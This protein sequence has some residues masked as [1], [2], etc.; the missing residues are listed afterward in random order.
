MNRSERYSR[1]LAALP[2]AVRKRLDGRGALAWQGLA[3]RA[4]VL[5]IEDA[6]RTESRLPAVVEALV[7][8]MVG[9]VGI[10]PAE[11]AGGIEG[12][13]SAAAWMHGIVVE[14]DGKSYR[15]RNERS[16]ELHAGVRPEALVGYAV[17]GMELADTIQ[18]VCEAWAA[19]GEKAQAVRE[20][21]RDTLSLYAGQLGLRLRAYHT[22]ESGPPSTVWLARVLEDTW[23]A[24]SVPAREALAACAI[25]DCAGGRAPRAHYYAVETSCRLHA[26]DIGEARWLLGLSAR[27]LNGEAAAAVRAEASAIRPSPDGTPS[28]AARARE[29]VR[30]LP[31]G[32]SDGSRPVEDSVLR[33]PM[34]EPTTG[35]NGAGRNV[36]EMPA[37]A[38]AAS[39]PVEDDLGLSAALKLV[40]ASRTPAAADRHHVDP[41]LLKGLESLAGTAQDPVPVPAAVGTNQG[42]LV[43]GALAGLQFGTTREGGSP[44]AATE[45]LAEAA[46]RL[47]AAVKQR[48][49]EAYGT[50]ASQGVDRLQNPDGISELRRSL[51]TTLPGTA[52]PEWMEELVAALLLDTGA[53]TRDGLRTGRVRL[54]PEKL[55]E[56]HK[57]IE[58][59]TSEWG[60]FTPIHFVEQVRLGLNFASGVSTAVT[61]LGGAGKEAEWTLLDPAMQDESLSRIERTKLEVTRRIGQE[62]EQGR[63]ALAE[64][65]SG[66]PSSLEQAALLASALKSVRPAARASA[67]W[68]AGVSVPNPRNPDDLARVA[69]VAE[70][71]HADVRAIANRL[72]AIWVARGHDDGAPR[73]R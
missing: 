72:I 14:P 47:P 62:I 25:T 51:G 71:L 6:V 69:T 31:A 30:Q 65:S 5:G 39:E 60:F 4:T 18:Q 41:R 59:E 58:V 63:R 34:I 53:Q 13:G 38:G 52:V 46:K 2:D 22:T 57:V 1:A 29:L 73:A 67:G 21:E 44:A 16:S 15:L 56:G 23:N 20:S 27:V 33:V 37:R 54:S 11:V 42:R 36:N 48:I 26:F 8:R 43:R 68:P 64:N 32:S 17:L 10:A 3:E 70:A 40:S 61:S 9:E 28:L 55:P 19:A 45:A 35:A 7:G 50:G 66:I 24:Q 12:R 49:G